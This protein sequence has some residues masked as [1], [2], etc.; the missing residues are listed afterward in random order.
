MNTCFYKKKPLETLSEMQWRLLLQLLMCHPLNLH[1]FVCVC[2][3]ACVYA[4]ERMPLCTCGGPRTMRGS[5]VP[6]FHHAGSGNRTRV[7]RVS[8]KC[9]T[10]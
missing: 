4:G 10:H 1:L 6:F 8:L 9:F 3:C 7:V 5:G 2:A